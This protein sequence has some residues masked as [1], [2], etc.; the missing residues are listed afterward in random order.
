ME[1]CNGETSKV[2][3]LRVNCSRRWQQ[4]MVES[5]HLSPTLPASEP[6]KR[7]YTTRLSFAGL[8]ACLSA[9]YWN[10]TSCP[11]GLY[12]GPFCMLADV[13]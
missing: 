13:R 5:W 10:H 4:C 6:C 12:L 8:N 3:V 1:M 11:F 7:H 9:C 2:N